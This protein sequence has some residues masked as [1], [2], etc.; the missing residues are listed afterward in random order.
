MSVNSTSGGTVTVSQG[1]LAVLLTV[2]LL[3]DEKALNTRIT[4]LQSQADISR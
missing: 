3:G 2:D 1:V 4:S